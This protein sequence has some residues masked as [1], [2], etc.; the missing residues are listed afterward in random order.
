ME[1]EKATL[2]KTKHCHLYSEHCM[3][4]DICGSSLPKACGLMNRLY[5]QKQVFPVDFEV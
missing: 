4:C 2:K 5:L 1:E 3:N